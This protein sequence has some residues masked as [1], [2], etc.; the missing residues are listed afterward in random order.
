MDHREE[1]LK[2]VWGRPGFK[3]GMGHWTIAAILKQLEPRVLFRRWWKTLSQGMTLAC[4]INGPWEFIVP[5]LLTCKASAEKHQL[6]FLKIWKS[7]AQGR[8]LGKGEAEG[9]AQQCHCI[10]AG[11]LGRHC[12]FL[13][14]AESRV[15][16]GP[17]SRVSP[18]MQTSPWRKE[19]LLFMSPQG[20]SH[21]Y[22]KLCRQETILQAK[23][24]TH[25]GCEWGGT[26]GAAGPGELPRLSPQDGGLQDL[27]EA[28]L[29]SRSEGQ[30]QPGRAAQPLPQGQS[31]PLSPPQAAL[32]RPQRWGRLLSR[33]KGQ[34]RKRCRNS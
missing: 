27:G 11:F 10:P 12:A 24:F 4:E 19:P 33:R 32:P 26:R 8:W 23:L 16:L 13:C 18:G 31:W 15:T 28:L 14:P 30:T 34:P 9:R 5:W 29:P 22:S 1:L 20:G 21:P 25:P 3:Q 2:D 17:C 7:S 6:C